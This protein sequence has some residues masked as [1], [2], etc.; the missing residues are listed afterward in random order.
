MI[1]GNNKAFSQCSITFNPNLS[2]DTI[3]LTLNTAGVTNLNHNAL[4]GIFVGSSS[5][6]CDT[7]L[8]FNPATNGII[9]N[10]DTMFTCSDIGVHSFQLAI[11]DGDEYFNTPDLDTISNKVSVFVK[12]VDENPP[13]LEVTPRD[14]AL[15][16]LWLPAVDSSFCQFTVTENCSGQVIDTSYTDTPL[17]IAQGDT[18]QTIQRLWT[19]STMNDGIATDTQYIHIR[20]TVDAFWDTTMIQSIVSADSTQ[21]LTDSCLVVLIDTS[22]SLGNQQYNF[23]LSSFLPT[24]IDS[25]LGALSATPVVTLVDTDTI[26][27]ATG[28]T[29]TIRLTYN[30]VDGVGNSTG[31]GPGRGNFKVSLVMEDTTAPEII[32]MPLVGVSSVFPQGM[33]MI[34]TFLVYVDSGMCT[35]TF[36]A[37]EIDIQVRDSVSL[38]SVGYRWKV[39]SF[40]ANGAPVSSLSGASFTS[41]DTAAT[42]PFVIGDHI[43]TYIYQDSTCGGAPNV[44][45]LQFMLKVRTWEPILTAGID[46]TNP[47]IQQVIPGVDTT[48]VFFSEPNDCGINIDSAALRIIA[49]DTFE[50]DTIIYR[51]K[52]KTLAGTNI[53]SGSTPTDTTSS[54]TGAFDAASNDAALFYPVGLHELTYMFRDTSQSGCFNV[55]SIKYLI[56]VRDTGMTAISMFPNAAPFGTSTSLTVD[57]TTSECTE[58]ISFDEPTA[59]NFMTCQGAA[60]GV[61]ID[62]IF[63]SGPDPDV[64]DGKPV[65]DLTGN[66][67]L[68]ATFPV[69]TTVFRYVFTDTIGTSDSIDLTV[70]VTDLES[71]TAGCPGP[72]SIIPDA[73]CVA[74]LP[75]YTTLSDDNCELDT[76]Q[77][78][79][80]V[81]ATIMNDT[82]VTIVA[83]DISG[84]TDTCR[85]P[86]T[87]TAVAPVPQVALVDT[88]TECTDLV[89]FAPIADVDCNTIVYGIPLSGGGVDLMTSPPSYSFSGTVNTNATVTWLFNGSGGTFS[90]QSQ[91]ISYAA[92][93]TPPVTSATNLTVSLDSLGM[94]TF[95]PASLGITATDN[96]SA[97][98][99]IIITTDISSATCDTVNGFMVLKIYAEDE[100]GNIDSTQTITVNIID[101]RPPDFIGVPADTMLSCG[102]AVPSLP[103]IQIRDNCTSLVDSILIDTVSTRL[104]TLTPRDS[105]YYNYDLK[106]IWTATDDQNNTSKDS[107]VYMFRDTEAPVIPY[108]NPLQ[109]GSSPAAVNCSANVSLNLLGDITENCSDTVFI[110]V[111]FTPTNGIED[112]IDTTM[113]NLTIPMGSTS[114]IIRAR[115]V[116]G[117]E[118]K[119]TLV[120]E[121]D[122]QTA[123]RPVCVQSVSVT[124]NPLGFVKL[125]P[126]DINLNSSDNC[127]ANSDLVFTLIGRDSF[128]CADVGQTFS[129]ELMVT[130]EAGLFASCQANVSIDDF[131]GSGTFSCPANVTIDCSQYSQSTVFGFPT[132]IDVCGDSSALTYVD[133]IVPGG[134]GACRIVQRTWTATDGF[135]NATSCTQMINLLDTIA[136]TFQVAYT[137]TIVSCIDMAITA[138]SV[139][140]QD[141]CAASYMVGAT[142]T[143][144]ISGDTIIITKN[145]AATDGCQNIAMTQV[146]KVLDTAAPTIAVQAPAPATMVGDT[147][148][149]NTSDFVP[150]SCGVLVSLNI[151]SYI[152]D[153]NS[154]LGLG[155]NL[156]GVDTN[157]VVWSNYFPVGRTTLIIGA[158]D[159]V[160]NVT[161]KTVYIDVRDTSVPTIVCVGNRTISLGTGGTGVLQISDV[162][163]SATDN[164][165][166]ALTI[167]AATLS[168]STFDCTD[169]GL[170]SVTLSVVDAAGNIGTCTVNVDVI[171][172][173]GTSIINIAASAT[174]ETFVGA[175]DGTASVAVSG[176]S[177][178]YTY[179]WSPGGGTTSTITNLA[180][181]AYTVVVNDATSGCILTETVTVGNGGTV[182]YTLGS[183]SGTTGSIVQIPVTV[184]NFDSVAGFEMRFTLGNTAV[185]QFVNGNEAGGFNFPGLTSTAFQ[186]QSAGVLDVTSLPSQ[187][188]T[189]PDGSTIFFINV[190]LTGTTGQTVALNMTP[191]AVGA[192]GIETTIIQNGSATAVNST[193]G[194]TTITVDIMPP[195]GASFGGNIHLENNVP[196]ENVEVVLSGG[197]TGVDS[198]DAAGDYVFNV[199]AS[200]NLTVTPNENRLH[201][202]GL[203]VTD[204]AI[205]QNHILGNTMLDSPYKMIAADV[206]GNE[207][208]TV[209][210]L[211]E[212]QSVILGIRSEFFTAPSWKFIPADFPITLANPWA[213]PIPMSISDVTGN[214]DF[215]AVKMGDVNLT[216]TTVNLQTE[217]GATSRDIFRF[218]VEDRMLKAG[219]VIEVPF[220]AD[221]FTD[222][223]AYQM[224][225]NANPEYLTFESATAGALTDIDD[226]NF[227][228]TNAARGLISTLWYATEP[229]NIE[230]NTTLFTI[231]FRVNKG[232][233]YLSDILRAS[234]DMLSAEAYE[235][236]ADAKNISLTFDKNTVLEGFELFQNKPN[237]FSA[238]TTI[239][240][241]LPK[242]NSATVRFFDFS[243]RMVHQIKGAY[244]AGLNN[245]VVHKNDL[246]GSGVLYYEL[247]TPS[248]TARKK[249]IVLD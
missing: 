143:T 162:F 28:C 179:A 237:P 79:P 165:D 20:D 155:I 118:A 76:V 152:T 39:E 147:L 46:A 55:D 30:A 193:G 92:D 195:T 122:D 166:G 223:F 85:F 181:G 247:A 160:G 87:I 222:M 191:L 124:I 26:A 202:K 200:S 135:G 170:Q 204:L 62:R 134:G 140:V 148:F 249:M 89:L 72:Q 119:D 172:G 146:I 182:I 121:V 65:V 171:N 206:N 111:D 34:D 217:I 53:A 174:D 163:S 246:S 185:A 66:D 9:S 31:T 227:G 153:C 167:A 138:D 113:V 11:A 70:T 69:G 190:L 161:T 104:S 116:V 24:A 77:Q 133:A 5:A 60:A 88:T 129:I 67:N 235:E 38:D 169:L 212:I 209:T 107:V 224:T 102:A 91:T 205:I 139:L 29:D 44:D 99:D 218:G 58:S 198:T 109:V 232:G 131:T 112:F 49:Q 108:V 233:K 151:A 78:F 61:T 136:P 3:K 207:R 219:E 188:T 90:T 186:Y 33:G 54:A 142:A 150:D 229:L 8:I 187:G 177:G 93:T 128:T 175:N 35:K 96:C 220:K 83:I 22:S 157:A 225:I 19:V 95:T 213:N 123:P 81:G 158:A 208:I 106:Y 240:F 230:Q 241:S 183:G 154:N 127:T 36:L 7:V 43:V 117:N 42:G 86:V 203:T 114:I 126:S 184:M 215:I 23:Y 221:N 13:S 130:D 80:A 144:T 63:V 97:D 74:T 45:S 210:D 132:V 245:I 48:I 105:A 156:N 52:I 15:N 216:A 71:P 98:S 194:S 110:A 145:W 10:N 180:P 234:S 2:P 37:D 201:N 226:N 244:D 211:A 17:N 51:W 197:S 1:A 18:V 141:D 68:T 41:N 228:L 12:V 27:S 103:S 231:S 239:S 21:L 238:E 243:G 59:T 125:Q 149:F 115:D 199:A 137:D 120:I 57:A 189:L 101:N 25:C 6:S 242:A 100:A 164:C 176:G 248:F 50:N 159:A 32:E 14:T 16:C 236:G 82:I 40:P 168:Q 75:D 64:F 94:V 192:T 73:S 173:T 4:F 196:L 56:S 214:N 84:N 178:N 47:Q